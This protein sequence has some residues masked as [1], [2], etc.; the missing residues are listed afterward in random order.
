M[1]HGSL[2]REGMGA[3]H[4]WDELIHA[5]SKQEEVSWYLVSISLCSDRAVASSMIQIPGH[6]FP[7]MRDCIWEPGV[8]IN[9]FIKIRDIMN[10]AGKWIE[11]ESVVLNE[12]AQ[13]QKGPRG[14]YSLISRC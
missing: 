3:H 5:L 11:L 1:T 2:E 14:T 6:T 9:P 13:T 4:S 7:S 8:K 10:F 12:V